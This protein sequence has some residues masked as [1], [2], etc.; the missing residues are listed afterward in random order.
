ME[1]AGECGYPNKTC[2]PA[3]FSEG[4]ST[5]TIRFHFTQG[6]KVHVVLN[7]GHQRGCEVVFGNISQNKCFFLPTW[8]GSL[9]TGS[10]GYLAHGG[11]E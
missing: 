4:G 11:E 6:L 1:E 2:V 7:V 5:Q 9:E 8:L 3:C 10:G